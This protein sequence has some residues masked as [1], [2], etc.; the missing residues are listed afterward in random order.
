MNK[1]HSLVAAF[2]F[3][4]VTIATSF[5]LYIPK[6]FAA[7]EEVITIP[8]EAIRLRILANSNSEQDQRIKREIRDLVNEQITEWV[9]DLTSLEEAREVI[10]EHLD[11]I[12]DLSTSVLE[13]EKVKQN[14]QVDFGKVAFPT[15]LYGQFLY[16]AGTYEA[17]LI[18]IGEGNGA[19]WWCVLFPPLCFLD[20]SSS[21]AIQDD[22]D[23][24]ESSTEQHASGTKT[25]KKDA[26]FVEETE[27][28][29]EVKF[30]LIEIIE[31]IISFFK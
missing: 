17:V 4:V 24:S 30:F 10:I 6:S 5:S 27:E 29:P 13:R 14:V 15:K 23:E 8:K 1:N 9:D 20:F 18:T 26:H 2:F 31:K 3:I 28:E 25:T 7:N 21:S 19:N 11:E 16:P 22:P 12:E